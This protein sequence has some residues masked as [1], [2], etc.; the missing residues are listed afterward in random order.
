MPQPN[1]VVLDGFTLNP[2]DLSW[3]ALESLG[4]CVI[5]D[6]SAPG[7]VFERSREAEI[8]LTNKTVLERAAILS[9]PRLRYIGVMATGYNIVDAAAARERGVPV[10]N[11]PVYGTTSVAQMT[12]ALLLE[13]VRGV[14][15]HARTVREGRW[16]ASPDFCYWDTPQIE[17]DGLTMGIVGFGRIGREVARIAR[18]FN[19]RVL[20]FDTGQP[21]PEPEVS[22]VPFD[23][24]FRES[25]IVS[26]HCPLTP[27]SREMVNARRLALMKTGAFL[28]NTSRGP[29]VNERDLA[30]A[31][32]S[33]GVAGAALDVLPV[34]PPPTDDPLIRARNCIITPHIAWATLAARKRLLDTVVEN[35]RA[36]LRGEPD[37]VVN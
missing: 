25:D 5:H 8:L 7:E 24:L 10:T 4:P 21:A 6:R 37:N 16:S 29:L 18:A 23:N 30:E 2:G 11:V 9:L 27:E 15:H 20:A 34:E 13:L 3:N 26:L 19:M 31:L 22:F 33:G 28:L 17:L 12:F 1:I 36:F 14:G 35:V 32:N